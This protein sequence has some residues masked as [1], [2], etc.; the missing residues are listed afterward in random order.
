MGSAHRGIEGAILGAGGVAGSIGVGGNGMGQGI[1]QGGD[2]PMFVV[3]SLYEF[4]IDRQRREAGFPYLT[5]VQGEVFDVGSP[6]ARALCH[7][8][9]R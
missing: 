4:N 3:V 6:S 9:V 7:V 1:Q 8:Y 2:K 5:Y